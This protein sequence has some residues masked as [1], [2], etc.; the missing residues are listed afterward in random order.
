LVRTGKHFVGPD[1]SGLVKSATIVL[2]LVVLLALPTL[3]GETVAPPQDLQA[4]RDGARIF[5]SWE[6]P[7]GNVT[8]L[9]YYVYRGTDAGNITFYDS[10]DGNFTAGYDS[11][12]LRDR[13]YYYAISAI[14]SEGE[15]A[16]SDVAVVSPPSDE[17]PVIVMTIIL[18][19]VIATLILAYR[20]GRSSE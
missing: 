8:V 7:P 10:V 11:E 12:V 20:K 2:L 14:T 4:E 1:Q 5:I 3:A 13:T 9:E 15:G 6:P 17:Y 16:L 18:A 19:V